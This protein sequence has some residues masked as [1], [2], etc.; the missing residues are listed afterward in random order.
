MIDF[1]A[2]LKTLQ[3]EDWDK[4][5]NKN[6]TVKDVVAHMVGWEKGD[7][8]V[9]RTAWETKQAPWFM[10]TDDYDEFN[11]KAV[12]YYKDYSSNELIEEWEKWQQRVQDE[13]DS[14]GEDNLRSRMDLFGWL[15]KTGDGSHYDEHYKQIKT[16]VEGR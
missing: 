13:I 12:E 14:I 5:V 3:P 7:V 8:D 15:F 11:R 9:I 10:N 4:K 2:Y 1:I 6:W 16:T